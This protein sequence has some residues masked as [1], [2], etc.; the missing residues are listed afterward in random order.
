[1]SLRSLTYATNI[2]YVMH[3]SVC[4]R[5][6]RYITYT[7]TYNHIHT[8]LRHSATMIFGYSYAQFITV[9]LAFYSCQMSVQKDSRRLTSGK[10]RIDF[11][12][13]WFEPSILE[14]DSELKCPACPRGPGL[15]FSRRLRTRMTRAGLGNRMQSSLTSSYSSNENIA[16]R[17]SNLW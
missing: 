13:L 2:I 9:P 14:R 5:I 15:T 12:V 3:E 10:G 6:R 8:Y 17:I 16:T 4:V 1:M 7:H 11:D